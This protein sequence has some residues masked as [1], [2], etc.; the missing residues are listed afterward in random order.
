VAARQ[1]RQKIH[2]ASQRRGADVC[3]GASMSKASSSSVSGA[4]D[5]FSQELVVELCLEDIATFSTKV[6]VRLFQAYFPILRMCAHPSLESQNILHEI[7]RLQI[8]AADCASRQWCSL[9]LKAIQHARL[10][11]SPLLHRELLST[12]AGTSRSASYKLYLL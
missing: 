2:K 10:L 4:V 1:T 9:F 11:T 7:E 5:H 3:F 6:S 8:R 12:S